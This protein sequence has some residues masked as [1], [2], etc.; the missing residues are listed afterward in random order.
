MTLK[1]TVVLALRPRAVRELHVDADEGSNATQVL[2]KSGILEAVSPSD[3]DQL[4]LAI[5]GRKAPG[6]QVLKDGDRLE[7]LRPLVVDPKHARRERFNRQG[8][9]KAGLFKARRTGGK[10]G[11]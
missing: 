2:R 4:E 9:K 7:L 5:W 10:A 8:A 1:V 6:T 3:I 11:Y